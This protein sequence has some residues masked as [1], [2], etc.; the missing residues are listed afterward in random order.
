[1]RYFSSAL[2]AFVLMAPAAAFAAP[3]N[4]TGNVT[5]NAIFGSGNANGSFTGVSQAY[6]IPG[7]PQAEFPVLELGLRAKL[8]FN[9]ANSPENTFNY[10][11]VD[12]YSFNTGAAPGG[13]SFDANSPTTPVW[14]F[15]WHIGTDSAFAGLPFAGLT[16]LNS[17]TYELRIDGDPTAGTNFAVF[18]P[19]NVPFADHAL[20]ISTTGSGNGTTATDPANYATLLNGQSVAQNSWNYE[21]FNE[22]T[23]TVFL[24]Q[25]SMFD[26]NQAGSYRIELE[27]F[28]NGTSIAST[29][30]NIDISP[31]PLPASS[32]LLLGGLGAFVTLR[33]RKKA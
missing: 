16:S 18:D 25:L 4:N 10:D 29:G 12:T 15:E 19:I 27:A 24:P 5:S 28:R 30:I 6:D 14:N 11:G 26:P 9:D 7:T 1:M 13:F 21:F 32:L 3:I 8:R 31:V 22:A 23:D 2:A 17:F 20:G 33:R